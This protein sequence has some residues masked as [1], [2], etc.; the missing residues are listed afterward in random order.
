MKRKNL[1]GELQ[2][3]NV[4][5]NPGVELEQYC[6][7]PDT[8]AEILHLVGMDMNLSGKRV[9]DLG[10]GSGI[11]GLGTIC[12]GADKVLGVDID[13]EA[14]KVAEKN[15]IC[16][17]L[18]EDRVKYCKIDVRIMQKDDLPA[19]WCKFDVVVSNPP[20]GTRDCNVD[21]LFVK[22]GLMFADTVYSVHKSS[23]RAFWKKLEKEMDVV[24]DIIIHD[25][26]FPIERTFKFHRHDVKDIVVDVIKFSKS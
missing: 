2:A 11:L 16:M 8:A 26:Q 1:A 6:T 17:D 18:D 12:L 10:C 5:E 20:F 7:P 25:L 21:Q 13:S 23:T 22:K 14:L 9:L 24:V 19:D 4:I 3:L 15:R